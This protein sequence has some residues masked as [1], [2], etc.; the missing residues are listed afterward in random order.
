MNEL[1][2]PDIV[3]FFARPDVLLGLF[4][5]ANFDETEPNAVFTPFGS[6]CSSIVQYPFLEKDATRPRSVLGLFDVTVCPFVPKNT[7]S[8]SV[9]MLKFE[10]MIHNMNESFLIADSWQEIQKRIQRT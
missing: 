8:F 1:D 5:L 10:R 7:L 9:P 6:G 3:V 2:E 4:A